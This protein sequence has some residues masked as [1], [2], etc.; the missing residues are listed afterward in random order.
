[1]KRIMFVLA[2][3][4]GSFLL[5][6]PASAT[7][8]P[9]V[10]T[11]AAAYD[12][13]VIDPA[14]DEVVVDHEAYDEVVLDVEGQP[15]I[16][17]TDAVY[18]VEYQFE[19]APHGIYKIRWETDPNW[20]ADSNPHSTGW[21]ST[22]VTRDGELITPA[23]EGTP[24]VDEVSHVVTHEAVTHV[25]THDAV[26]HVVHHDAVTC[27]IKTPGQLPVD[28]PCG[29][30]NAA[31]VY[32][33]DT[34]NDFSWDLTD[35]GELS[36]HAH[37]GYT[38]ADGETVIEFGLAPD[39]EEACPVV[40]V[41][42]VDDDPT[43]PPVDDDPVVVAPVVD[44]VAPVAASPQPATFAAQPVAALPNTGG[45]SALLLTSGILL[46][47][48]GAFIVKMARKDRSTL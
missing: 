38:F 11:P 28:D 40:V 34:S 18:A 1:M 7:S 35:A 19:H 36:A 24:A 12:E 14:Y 25:V 17:G 41:P 45:P 31:W 30:G 42:P 3:V 32:S 23:T 27:E 48:I 13:T 33:G 6:S 16:P 20:N 8:E 29:I 37:D 10:C 15:A 2:L 21:R 22:G 39:S 26:T 9:Q 4:M 43:I 5:V 47:L 44:V 46:A